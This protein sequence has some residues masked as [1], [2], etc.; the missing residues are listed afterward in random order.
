MA[1][2]LRPARPTAPGQIIKQEIEARG[3]SQ[4][5]LAAILGRPE[6]MVSEVVNGIKQITPETA[7]ELAQASPLAART[8]SWRRWQTE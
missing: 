6:Q 2:M 1:E 4:K 7:L 8:P 3:W 5:D